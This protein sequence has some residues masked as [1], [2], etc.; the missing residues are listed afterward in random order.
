MPDIVGVMRNLWVVGLLAAC[1]GGV[2]SAVDAGTDADVGQEAITMCVLPTLAQTVATLAGCSLPGTADGARGDARFNNPTNVL[3][4]PNGDTYVTDFDSNRLRMIDRSAMT[5]T[6]FQMTNW[7]KPF[8]IALAPNGKLYVETDDNDRGAHS[9]NTGTLWLV[10][11]V[12]HTAEVVGRDLGRPR[13]IVPLP[14]GR[15]ALS[16][17]MHHCISL[18]DPTTGAMSP[19]AGMR[20]MPGYAN[21]VGDAARFA[22][23]YDMVLMPDGSLAVA[24]MDNHRIRRVQLDGTVTDIAGSGEIGTL[25]GPADVATFDAPQGLAVLPIG[26]LFVT[27]VKRKIV[28]RIENGMVTT[29][30]G[31]GTPGWLDADSPRD[32]RFY[33]LEGIDVDA[34]RIVVADGNVGDGRPYNHVRVIQLS[35]LP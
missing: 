8:G 23:P 6:T 13:G 21:G 27:D 24:D 20:D 7:Q 16:D 30:A 25:N 31:D 1:G 12:A 4:A 10:D 11:P 35:Q 18:L 9:T 33:G 17:Y 5:T 29:I 22:Q 26:T 28:R 32:T 2:D 3:I 14:D 34:A 15:L 19:L